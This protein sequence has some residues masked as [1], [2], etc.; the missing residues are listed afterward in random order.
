MKEATF[1]PQIIKNPSKKVQRK[2]GVKI[3]DDLIRRA[4]VIRDKKEA[5]RQ[6]HLEHHLKECTFTPKLVSKHFVNDSTIG[7]SNK[8]Y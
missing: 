2:E 1:K 5:N 7:E 3:E 6:K 8:R 4:K